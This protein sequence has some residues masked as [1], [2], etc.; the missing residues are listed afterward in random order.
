M[1]PILIDTD[2]EKLKKNAQIFLNTVGPNIQSQLMKK[3]WMSSNYVTDWWETYVYL[4]TRESIMIN[5]NYYGLAP[6]GKCSEQIKLSIIYITVLWG[7]R[8]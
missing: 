2:F 3:W 7:Y 6:K 5:S 4:R 8:L 1:R